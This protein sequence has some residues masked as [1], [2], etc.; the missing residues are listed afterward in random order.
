MNEFE[1]CTA[2][3]KLAAWEAWSSDTTKWVVI[4]L[5][6]LVAAVFGFLCGVFSARPKKR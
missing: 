3:F 2:A 6:V 4:E 1:I 5:G